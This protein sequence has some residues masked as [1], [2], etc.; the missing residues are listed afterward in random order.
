MIWPIASP[1]FCR[2]RGGSSSADGAEESD[3]SRLLRADS[4]GLSRIPMLDAGVLQ[5]LSTR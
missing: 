5:V 1:L 2:T 4:A 3:D